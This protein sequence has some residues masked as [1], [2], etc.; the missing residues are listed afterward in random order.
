MSSRY[1]NLL[2]LPKS[3]VC[4]EAEILSKY[5]KKLLNNPENVSEINEAVLEVIKSL[6][7]PLVGVKF[8]DKVFMDLLEGSL[9]TS[10]KITLFLRG[11]KPLSHSG[12]FDIF[13]KKYGKQIGSQFQRNECEVTVDP[14]TL[15]RDRSGLPPQFPALKIKISSN[16]SHL[17]FELFG[18]SGC[19]FVFFYLKKIVET[20]IKKLP[21][22][23]DNCYTSPK[24]KNKKC[25]VIEFSEEDESSTSSDDYCPSPIIS[26]STRIIDRPITKTNW[27]EIGTSESGDEKE[28]LSDENFVNEDIQ[29]EDKEPQCE[30]KAE[31]EELVFCSD[32]ALLNLIEN[33]NQ[34]MDAEL[35]INAECTYLCVRNKSDIL[36]CFTSKLSDLVCKTELVTSNTIPQIKRNIGKLLS[37]LKIP[38]SELFCKMFHQLENLPLS[39]KIDWLFL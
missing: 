17:K 11:F 5:K 28:N 12:M 9:L 32:C 19:I 6:Q 23:I 10:K 7:K 34:I 35:E 4:K 22:K 14:V 2:G 24:N 38:L 31:I 3:T 36:S 13:K 20:F 37:E 1:L 29:M 21:E 27:S 26:R 25:E 39:K 18:D 15:P 16:T 33:G 30:S 8:V